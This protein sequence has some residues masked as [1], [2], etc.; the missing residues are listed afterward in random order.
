M[1][2]K[3][4]NEKKRNFLLSETNFTAIVQKLGLYFKAYLSKNGSFS[5]NLPR[6][7]NFKNKLN[8]CLQV[9]IWAFRI[10]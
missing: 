6:K 4:H 3:S 5:F 9:W 2:I 8:F 1:A 7:C 10:S